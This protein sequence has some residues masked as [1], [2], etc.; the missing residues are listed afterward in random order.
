MRTTATASLR[1]LASDG[2][3]SRSHLERAQDL[4]PEG[5]PHF[6]GAGRMLTVTHDGRVD[7]L[8][9]VLAFAA[10]VDRRKQ[11]IPNP[12]QG[13]AP[14]LPVNRASHAEVVVQVPARRARPRDPGDAIQ[15]REMIP[16]SP[17]TPRSC[18]DQAL[19]KAPPLLVRH[20]T[21]NHDHSPPKRVS[22]NQRF[23]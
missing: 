5:L 23:R 16:R 11:R 7:Q 20:H 12:R 17:A 6:F 9:V 22:L 19:R 18:L 1:Q 21:T 4:R 14:E 13:P 2:S 10:L 15:H 8:D 3:W